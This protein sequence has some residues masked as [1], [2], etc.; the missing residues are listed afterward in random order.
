M[1]GN[2]EASKIAGYNHI[3]FAGRIPLGGVLR[4]GLFPAR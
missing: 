2:L 1:P 4:F 3:K